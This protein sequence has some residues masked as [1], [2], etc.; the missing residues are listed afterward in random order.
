MF[1]FLKRRSATSGE[2][3][4]VSGYQ[5]QLRGLMAELHQRVADVECQQDRERLSAELA[6]S[7]SKLAQTVRQWQQVT[8]PST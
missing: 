7:E 2:M 4:S 1:G 8:S 5:H 6:Q 3:T